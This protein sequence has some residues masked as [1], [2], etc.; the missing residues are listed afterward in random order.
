MV[1]KT[2][3]FSG[4]MLLWLTAALPV[5]AQQPISEQLQINIAYKATLDAY[6]TGADT[7]QFITQ[8]NQAINLTEKA[9][10]IS[11]IDPQQTRELTNQAQAL[12]QNV[13]QQATATQQSNNS[14]LPIYSVLTAVTALV[15]GVAVY[16]FGPSAAWKIWFKLRKSYRVTIK[17]AQGNDKALII[18]PQ[19]VCAVL[20]GITIIIACIAV[21]GLILP[22]NVGEKYSELGILGPN[23]KLGDYPSSVVASEAVNLYV[24]VGN[25]MGQPML[26]TVK[27][28]LGNNDTA[29]NPANEA[30]LR[31]YQQVIPENQTW[32][33]PVDLTLNNAG[34]NQRL[35]FELWVYN[36]TTNSVQYHERWGQIWLNVTAPAV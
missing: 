23:M 7:Q 6:N 17:K 29:V 15:I 1:N 28:K 34:L 9:Q 13:T 25:H 31:Q 24:Y 30:A 32:T 18:T 11:N 20:F 22:K 3:L 14:L 10:Q 26:Y 4:F 12:I 33:F 5:I 19:Q 27:V 16:V 2:I 21:S 36:Q 8:L 35:I